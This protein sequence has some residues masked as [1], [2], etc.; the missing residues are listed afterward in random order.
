MIWHFPERIPVKAPLSIF[1]FNNH[2]ILSRLVPPYWLFRGERKGR[3]RKLAGGHETNPL[4]SRS[5]TAKTLDPSP[6]CVC[7]LGFSVGSNSRFLILDAGFHIF[8]VSS[9][10]LEFTPCYIPT[11]T[12]ISSAKLST[13][14]SL[15]NFSHLPFLATR[16]ADK[17]VREAIPHRIAYVGK[18]ISL[19]PS[20]S[21]H[22]TNFLI[23]LTHT[24][25]F[26]LWLVSK[27]KAVGCEGFP[28]HI[29]LSISYTDGKT[30]K[31][32]E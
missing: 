29:L 11:V 20:P 30:G 7:G 13:M 21:R 22:N 8:V 26:A 6:L 4:L 25:T 15:H 23:I 2:S 18:T 19:S 5:T 24:H 28:M 14:Y 32:R 27:E 10:E 3:K 31:G 9:L 17:H 1:L 16:F 12:H